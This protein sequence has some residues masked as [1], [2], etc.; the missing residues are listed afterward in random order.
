VSLI[1]KTDKESICPHIAEIMRLLLYN[2]IQMRH[3]FEGTHLHCPQCGCYIWLEAY[4]DYITEN[5]IPKE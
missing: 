4:G 3:D 2:N 1:A 5:D